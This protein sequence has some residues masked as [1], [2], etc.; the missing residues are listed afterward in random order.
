MEGFSILLLIT[1]KVTIRQ[2]VSQMMV[3]LT[4][5][6]SYVEGISSSSLLAKFNISNFDE[7]FMYFIRSTK[8]KD[9]LLVEVAILNDLIKKHKSN[10]SIL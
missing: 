9:K 8:E 3:R 4:F 7:I 6:H 5:L 10:F 2:L 1:K